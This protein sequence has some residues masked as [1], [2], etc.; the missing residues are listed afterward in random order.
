LRVTRRQKLSLAI[1][2]SSVVAYVLGA[3]LLPFLVDAERLRPQAEAK[4]QAALGRRVSLGPL[5]LTLWSG[6]ALRAEN[7]RI[8]ESLSA[9][10]TAVHVAW[11]PLLWKRVELRSITVED[12]SITQNE[13]RL[14]SA[15]RLASRVRV[16]PNGRVAMKGS[17]DAKLGARTGAPGVSAAFTAALDH[18]TLEIAALDATVG[19]LVHIDAT[20]RVTDMS[21]QA[22]RVA[23]VGQATLK[24][25]LLKGRFDLAVSTPPE[26][27]FDVGAPLL[28]VDEILAAAAPFR[29]GSTAS[30]AAVRFV[31][32]ANAAETVPDPGA[33]SFARMLVASGTLRADRCLARGVELTNLSMKATLERG[34]A[35]LR[36]ITFALY[37]GKAQGSQTLRLFEPQI[38]FSLE[39]TAEG[40][41]IRLL[42]AAL[43]PAQAGTVDG[44]ASLSVRLTGE[45]GG[46][47][48]LSSIHGV[49]RVAIEDG[50]LSSFGVIKQ[51]MSTLEVAGA[52][53]IARDETPFDH[54]S[55]SF[56]VVQG[57]AATKDLEFRSRDLDGDGAGTVGPGGVL[58]LDV[59]ASFS[60][61]V[62]DELV[63]KTHALSVRQGADG[64][65]SVPLQVRGTIH[66][67]AVQ[68]DLDK[69][70]NE[71]VLRA[72]KKE[73]TKSLLK[74]LLGR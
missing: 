16:A 46:T 7:L 51:V 3:T 23:L 4:L 32:E 54:L 36:D 50:T 18:G 34:V 63:A 27:T 8:G 64:R 42:I 44:T 56:D 60:K 26:A 17:I 39:Q 30:R 41:S 14:V 5:R 19:P 38:P 15:G 74:K 57:T 22:P 49:G 65:L 71:G 53:G 2:G 13:E 62:S 25:S 72:L 40:I 48:L 28:D 20:G 69:I 21:S 45:A 12:L 58:H 61:T 10:E 68:L 70:L 29:V 11:L 47:A 73:G 9:G 66:D 59:L 67:P 6:P 52:K 31:P 33:S 37:G 35:E 43:A 1:V 24:R 55:A